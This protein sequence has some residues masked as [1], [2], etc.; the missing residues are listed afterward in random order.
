MAVAD[1]LIDNIPIPSLKNLLERRE[2]S[3]QELVEIALLRIE[4]LNPHLNAFTQVRAEAALTEALRVDQVRG[5]GPPRP[6]L[7]IPMSVKDL[8][9][10]RELPTTAGSRVFGDGISS[11]HDA[12][13]VHRLRRAGAILIGKTNLHEFA[14]GV[15]GENSHFGPA[16]N[17]WDRS[18]IAGGSSGGSGV[19][20]AAGMGC[21]SIGTDTRGSI[22]IPS[23]FCGITG[24]KPTL[25]AVP[26]RG[27]IPLSGTLDHAGPMTRSVA[28]AETVFNVIRDRRRQHY[29][30]LGNRLR[31]GVPDNLVRGIDNEIR[32][33]VL[34]AIDE[35]SS[36]G[37]R[38]CPIDIPELEESVEASKAIAGA[39]AAVY[40]QQWI[41]Q[42]RTGY[43]PSVL[44]RLETGFE[45]PGYELVRAFQLRH[46]L[47]SRLRKVFRQVDCLAGASVPV[48]PRPLDASHL[49]KDGRLS[50]VLD[51]VR[52]NAP[53]NVAG[54]PALV[55]PCGTSGGL[56]TA[57]QL[58]APWHREDILFALG[59]QYQDTTDWHCRKPPL[60]AVAKRGQ[61]PQDQ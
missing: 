17:P 20:V 27:V 52:L 41:E 11:R 10:T 2:I 39:E 45:V 16:R 53:S 61:H 33:A 31:I 30:P 22:R 5:Q 51:L 19:A 42:N 49:E 9:E 57:L 6:L 12:T 46:R 32:R 36:L 3:S 8:I 7:G 44:A 40:H 56:P 1:S 21:F 48:F 28:D 43:D 54:V 26:T 18:R 29:P 37:H 60:E 55:F 14:Y 38:V 15:T 23:S 59:K 35:L 25:G 34:S 4:K 13:L 58:I 24:L 47:R 50:E